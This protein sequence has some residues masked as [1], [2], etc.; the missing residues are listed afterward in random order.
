[1]ADHLRAELERVYQLVVSE[2][3]LQAKA[4]LRQQQADRAGRGKHD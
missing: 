2:T 4:K 3:E 1:M